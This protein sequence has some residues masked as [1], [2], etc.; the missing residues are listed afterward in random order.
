LKLILSHARKAWFQ[1]SPPRKSPN[2][3]ENWREK[4]KIKLTI[5]PDTCYADSAGEALMNY[6]NHT[7]ANRWGYT[8]REFTCPVWERNQ[9]ILIQNLQRQH[10][11]V[12]VSQRKNMKRLRNI[13]LA[14]VI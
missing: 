14:M 2:V 5:D 6:L 9:L 8:T 10:F 13:V 7:N 3:G 11:V 12:D 1:R 4:M